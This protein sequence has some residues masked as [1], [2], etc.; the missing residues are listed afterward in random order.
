MLVVGKGRFELSDAIPAYGKAI[1]LGLP[2]RQL[3]RALTWLASSLS[4]T[5]ESTAALACIKRA[6]TLGGYRPRVEYEAIRRSVERRA[7]DHLARA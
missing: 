7:A 4:K 6:G 1:E 3:V 5:G 2:R